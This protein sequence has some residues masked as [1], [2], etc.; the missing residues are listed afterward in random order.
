MKYYW[1][2]I[3]QSI[4]V[5]SL[6]PS[7]AAPSSPVDLA[8]CLESLEVGLEIWN[9][10]DQ[11]VWFNKGDNYLRDAS[12]APEDVGKNFVTLQALDKGGACPPKEA[13][14]TSSLQEN[15]VASRICHKEPALQELSGDRWVKNFETMTP[16]GYLVIVRVNVTELVRQGRQLEARNH[17]LDLL[18][19]TDSM[20]GIANRRRFDEALNAEWQRA[21]RNANELS[22][23]MVDIDHFKKFNDC[24]GHLAGD[25]CLRRVAQVLRQCTRRAGDL[26]AR[27][28]GEEF[29]MLLPATDLSRAQEVAEKCMGAI[30]LEGIQHAASPTSP[31]LSVSIGVA[32]LSVPTIANPS[33]LISAADAA[34][35]RAKA[36]GRACY[37]IANQADWEIAADMPRTLPSPLASL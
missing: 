4:P 5:I 14:D 28:G 35:Y 12:F 34:L 25:A 19:N 8:S 9:E 16:D 30:Q 13:I 36:A 27:Y 26:A 15:M 29:V 11:L 22:L 37:A 32:C 33:A 1:L 18:S 7:S 24:Y 6:I 23:L 10:K 2:T 3:V 31:R 21:S 20:T 17:Q